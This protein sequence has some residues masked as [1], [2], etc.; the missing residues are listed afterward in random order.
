MKGI[1]FMKTIDVPENILISTYWPAQDGDD[2]AVGYGMQKSHLVFQFVLTFYGLLNQIMAWF[3]EPRV[4]PLMRPG[5]RLLTLLLP[6]TIFALLANR[7][8]K[9]TGFYKLDDE[10]RPVQYLSP[11][12]PK[13]IQGRIGV[14]RKRFF[15]Q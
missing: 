6:G 7:G 15:N 4:R 2:I 5:V 11:A 12:P 14:G 9:Y 1:F 3:L 8:R 10:G 13:S